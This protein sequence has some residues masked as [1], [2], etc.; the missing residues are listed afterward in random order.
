MNI[1]H[2]P[3]Y[4]RRLFPDVHWKMPESEKCVYLTFDDGPIPDITKWVLDILKQYEAK[5][6]FFCVGDNVLKHSDIYRQ[7]TEQGHAVGNHTFNHLNGMNTNVK[8]Y[9]RNVEQA[10]RY[11]QSNLFRPPHGLLKLRQKR[12][13]KSSYHIVMWDVLSRDFDPKVSRTDCFE[14]VQKYTTSGSIV[15]FHDSKKSETNLKY[16][17]PKTLEY[18]AGQGFSFRNININEPNL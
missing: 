7:I 12:I 9:I 2:P 11:V 13:I 14:I 10:A 6:T 8:D 17:L 5:A 16:A 4:I 18:F 1:E 3:M 15:V